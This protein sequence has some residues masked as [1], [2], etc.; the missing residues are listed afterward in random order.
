[1]LIRSNLPEINWLPQDEKCATKLVKEALRRMRSV[2]VLDGL[3]Y[4]TR[5]LGFDSYAFAI[6]AND[7]RPDAD[8]HPYILTDQPD[9]WL[10]IYEHRSYL[11]RDPRVPMGGE[12]GFCFW[13]AGQ[14]DH[15]PAHT[16]FLAEAAKYGIRSGLA[17]GQCTRDPPS[18]AMMA[19][20]CKSATL[21]HWTIEERVFIAGEA[22]VI[23]RIVSRAL[24]QFLNQQGLLYP[25]PLMKL[26]ER[27]TEVLTLIAAGSTSKEI[28][29]MLGVAKVTVE[30]EVQTSMGKL[31]AVNRYQAVARAVENKLIRT[32]DP[33]NAEYRSAKIRAIRSSPR[34]KG[35]K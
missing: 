13:E 18:Y 34:F 29:E 15:N 12:P 2:N 14:F 33:G 24:R 7:R 28:A 16:E 23:A 9:E 21:D 19:F 10:R 8:S 26:N 22:S 20:N 6:V 3:G 32:M 30:M 35:G 1:M 4:A 25:A 5:G 31:G 17:L 11:E 27:E